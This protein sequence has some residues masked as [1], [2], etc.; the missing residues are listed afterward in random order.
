MRHVLAGLLALVMV[1]SSLQ[2]LTVRAAGETYKAY[3]EEVASKLEPSRMTSTFYIEVEGGSVQSFCLNADKEAPVDKEKDAAVYKKEEYQWNKVEF[4]VLTEETV[5][6]FN[7]MIGKE[8]EKR[9]EGYKSG[10]EL[11]RW[12]IAVLRYY[13]SAAYQQLAAKLGIDRNDMFYSF[14]TQQ[15]VW[16][17]TD[18]TSQNVPQGTKDVFVNHLV[19]TEEKR[20]RVKQLVETPDEADP[21]MQHAKLVNG[22]YELC[23]SVVNLPGISEYEAAHTNIA[24]YVGRDIYYAGK[25][26][27]FQN[28][29]TVKREVPYSV[30]VSKRIINLA[31]DKTVNRL[32]GAKLTLSEVVD[33]NTEIVV[34]SFTTTSEDKSFSLFPGK[35]VLREADENGTD[36]NPEGFKKAD[37]IRFIVTE[38]GIEFEEGYTVP[39]TAELTEDKT[40]IMYDEMEE[41]P[42]TISKRA[43]SGSEEL[44]DG[45]LG[46]ANLAV[47][48]EENNVKCE[49]DSGTEPKTFTLPAGKYILRETTAPDGYLVAEEIEFSIDSDGNVSSDYLENGIIT[50]KDKPTKVTISKTDITGSKEICDAELSVTDVKTGTVVESWKSEE[51][52]SHQIVAKLVVGRVY[53]LTETTA[54]DGYLRAE[55]IYF[56]VNEK[57]EI[58]ICDENGGNAQLQDGKV[59]MKDCEEPVIEKEV[60]HKKPHE[61]LAAKNEVFTYTIKTEIPKMP[62]LKTFEVTDELDKILTFAGTAEQVK[63]TAGGTA[64]EGKAEI[65]GQTLTVRLTENDLTKEMQGKALTVEFTAKI[66]DDATEEQIDGYAERKI[67]NEACYKIN[68]HEKVKWSNTVTVTPKKPTPE[69]PKTTT[70]QT[71]TPEEPKTPTPEQPTT[72]VTVTPETPATPVT[73]VVTTPAEVLGAR[74][75]PAETQIVATPTVLGATRAANSPETGD[76]APVRLL[77][78]L[79]GIAAVGACAGVLRLRKMR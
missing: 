8:Q 7:S 44:L 32:S 10:E 74:R 37:D 66:R 60:N 63:V 45:E 39:E 14:A 56:F 26:K 6:K 34:E 23:Q 33:E 59:V 25:T 9:P 19:N 13:D 72:P 22:A 31:N 40:L 3:A 78:A 18:L 57:N 43:V 70:P 67:P 73:P 21:L 55:S 54:P 27:W 62:D 29:Y 75:D 36:G 46:G 42:V 16:K 38:N 58:Y 48:D 52:K 77:V 50:M 61:D 30:T 17:I 1:L 69:T 53:K 4:G 68:N 5:P 28:L 24:I 49:W 76:G 11:R 71:P 12:L 51:G 35:Y 41:A 79:M 20:A 64:L 47:L 15:A 65:S 2:S